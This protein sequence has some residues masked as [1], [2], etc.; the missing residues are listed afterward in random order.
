MRHLAIVLVLASAALLPTSRAFA[1]NKERAAQVLEMFE[2]GKK[3]YNLGDFDQAIVLWKKG[4]ELKDDPIFLYNIAQAYRQ[5]GDSQKAIFYYKGF[6]REDP[7]SDKRASVEARILELQR[8]LDAQQNATDAPPKGVGHPRV[9]DPKKT[10]PKRDPKGDPKLDPKVATLDKKPPPKD[11]PIDSPEKI[12]PDEPRDDLTRS[13][14]GGGLKTAGIITGGVGAGLVIL[15]I[16][17]SLNASST[18]RE[19]E[20]HVRSGMP[21][22]QE[23]TDKESSGRTQGTMAVLSIGIGAAAIIAG[24]TLFYLGLRKDAKAVEQQAKLQ[25]IPVVGPVTTGVLVRLAF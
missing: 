16:V 2:S 22:S 12:P 7:Q 13:G 25:I 15:G 4:Y 8:L 19:L 23:L 17:F 21:W 24:G 18:A 11:K 3:A 14:G 9:D 10:D 5:K 6:L 1:Q 20:D